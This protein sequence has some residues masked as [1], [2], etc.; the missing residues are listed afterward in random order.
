MNCYDLLQI[1]PR[2]ELDTIH[3]VYRMFAARYH[4]DNHD[5]GDAEKFRMISEA[6]RI[7]TDPAL[8]AEHDKKLGEAPKA[9]PVFQS[10]EFTDGLEAEVNIRV[11]VL[12]LLYAKRR[13]HA[14]FAALSFL[15][16]EQ[17]MAFPREHLH[18]AIWYLK[19]KRYVQQDDR[20]S[21]QITA[22]GVEFL[23]AQIP[24]NELLRRV[25]QASESGL[26]TYPKA[27]LVTKTS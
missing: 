8:R 21:F 18:F 19:S 13:A 22:D 20:S 1:H 16:L 2:A 25:F 6:H 17:L 11:G 27:L 9:I 3:R 12:C 4:P 14:E 7:L 10:K 24:G 26:M 23:E 5:T 15:D